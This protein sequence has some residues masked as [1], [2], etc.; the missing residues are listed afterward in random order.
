MADV[1]KE[2]EADTSAASKEEDK[3]NSEVSYLIIL[4]P[5]LLST[6]S[7]LLYVERVC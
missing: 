5:N 1:E 7:L 4:L 3:K 2:W 6:K